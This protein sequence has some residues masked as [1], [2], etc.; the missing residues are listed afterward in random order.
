MLPD[1]ARLA[2]DPPTDPDNDVLDQKLPAQ[3]KIL[4]LLIIFLSVYLGVSWQRLSGFLETNLG[5]FKLVLALVFFALGA[6]LL[7]G[8]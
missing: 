3:E 5:K 1:T 8:P 4:P 2:P 6:F 7:W